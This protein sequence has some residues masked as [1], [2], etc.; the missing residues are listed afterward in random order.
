[1]GEDPTEERQ[2]SKFPKKLIH[3]DVRKIIGKRLLYVGNGK[4]IIADRLFIQDRLSKVGQL[5]QF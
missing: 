1:M 4:D 5:L 3:K 2:P